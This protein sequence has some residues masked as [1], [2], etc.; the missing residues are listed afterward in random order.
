MLK[1]W[2]EE[3]KR[4]GAQNLLFF[5]NYCDLLEIPAFIQNPIACFF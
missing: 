2:S 1:E 5:I 3:K 4:F